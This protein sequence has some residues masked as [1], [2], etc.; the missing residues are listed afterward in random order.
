MEIN[1]LAVDVVI[2]QNEDGYFV[3]IR[4]APTGEAVAAFQAPFSPSE[5]ERLH[6]FVTTGEAFAVDEEAQNATL[7]GWGERLFR[8]LFPGPLY[9]IIQSSHRFAFQERA[10]L[11]IRL[12][13]NQLTP[14]LTMLPWE[15]LFDPVRKEFMALSLQSPFFRYT[16]LMHQIMPLKVEPPLRL[17]V[18]VSSPGGYPVF[19]RDQAWFTI[20]DQLDYLALEEKLVL[21]R[22]AKPT[23]FDLQR[24]LREKEFHLLHFIGHGVSHPLTG[25]SSLIFEDEMGRGRPVNGEHFGALLR[26]HFPLRLVTLTTSDE[27]RTPTANPFLT[28]ASNLIRRGTPAVVAT[29]SK[30]DAATTATFAQKFYSLIANFTPVDLAMSETRRALYGEQPNGAWGLPALFMRSPDGRLFQPLPVD[31]TKLAPDNGQTPRG[32]RLWP[33]FGRRR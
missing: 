9:S 4:N 21:E 29:Q 19:D 22:L 17:L 13:I 28:I 5:L 15:Y 30:L 10:C 1:Y 3:R 24:R 27:V 23:L 2:D 25:E 6:R 20:L 33:T 26:D 16:N 32:R 7:Q 12:E 18:V 14:A 8:A 31:Q 11:R